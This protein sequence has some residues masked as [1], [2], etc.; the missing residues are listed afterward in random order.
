VNALDAYRAMRR[1]RHFEERALDLHGEGR[2]IGSM[3]LANGQEAI[4]VG[5]CAV[6]EPRDALTATYRGHGWALARG[7]P[8]A[9]LFA[10][11]MGRD[12]PLNGGRGGSAY[13]SSADHGFLGEN[14]IVGAGVPIAAGAAMAARH[15]GDCSVSVVAI[16][17]GALNQGAVH[18]A[19]NLAAV[20]DLPLVVVVENNVY[21]ELTPI[22]DM[23][24][25][26]PLSRRADAY[27][28]PGV[29][30]E[31]RDPWAVRDAVGEAVDRARAGQGPSLVE[32]LCDRL[33]GHYHADPQTYRPP[34]DI[35]EARTREPLVRL[36]ARHPD[37]TDALDDIDAEVEAEIEAAIAAAAAVPLPPVAEVL[38][39]LH[40]AAQ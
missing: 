37:L 14:S 34:G 8:A 30:V 38:E 22:R 10:E 13:L 21:S 1:I 18:E 23:V 15:H 39:H 20:L 6:L 3:H 36:R 7:V 26:E 27:G 9:D 11:L 35:E 40:A 33:V 29:T 16:G 19:L 17:E 2:I 5:T 28:L 25:V 32:A 12:A 24:R 31:G 4:P